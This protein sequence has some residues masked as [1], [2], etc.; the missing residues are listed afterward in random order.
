VAASA[1]VD[2][3]YV[4]PA[5]M[6]PAEALQCRLVVHRVLSL[7]KIKLHYSAGPMQ[8]QQ[9]VQRFMPDV[10]EF[11]RL[12]LPRA[13]GANRRPFEHLQVGEPGAT[14]PDAD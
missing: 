10:F 9:D 13:S 5:R 4:A 11:L 7:H 8:K 14:Q 6:P 12:D 3:V 2:Q 1:V